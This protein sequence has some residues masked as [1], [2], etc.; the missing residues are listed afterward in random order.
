MKIKPTTGPLLVL[1]FSLL[2]T[3]FAVA[4]GATGELTITISPYEATFDGAGWKVDGQAFQSSGDVVSIGAGMHTVTF[5]SATGWI[6]PASQAVTVVASQR[7]STT[8]VYR[9]PVML[10]VNI[11]PAGAISSG[12]GWRLYGWGQQWLSSGAT[13]SLEGYVGTNQR[14]EFK[15]VTG[16]ST[17]PSQDFTPTANQTTTLTGI[18]GAVGYG[19][20]KVDLSPAAAVSAGAR[21]QVDG[22]ALQSSGVTLSGLVVGNH[23]LS[24]TN[25]SG[26]STPTSKTV[27]VTANQTTTTTGIYKQIGSLQVTLSPPGAVSAG[28]QWQVDGGAWQSSGA[29]VTGLTPM[30]VS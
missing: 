6:T 17:P 30:P 23:I 2:F 29:T 1:G 19:S 3:P 5:T 4:F 11:S 12:A 20:L 26:W 10:I 13:I 27:T 9:K 8:G 18:Y 7:T 28:A 22:G 21:W 15:D 24:F 14:V 25:V 16:W